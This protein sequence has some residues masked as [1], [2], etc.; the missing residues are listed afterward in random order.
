[1]RQIAVT[2]PVFD[3]LRHAGLLV[4]IPAGS[5]PC[6][7]SWPTWGEEDPTNDG[8]VWCTL[9]P[10]ATAALGRALEFE[11]GSD[12]SQIALWHT[13]CDLCNQGRVDQARDL[14]AWLGAE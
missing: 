6:P 9:V 8:I 5:G 2:A 13:A 3:A 14:F 12:A 11:I 10:A 7:V 4:E 1:M